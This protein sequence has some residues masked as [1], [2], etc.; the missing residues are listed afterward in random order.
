VIEAIPVRINEPNAVTVPVAVILADDRAIE[1]P[2]ADTVASPNI[3][4]DADINEKPSAVTVVLQ[5][6]SAFPNTSEPL[7][8][9]VIVALQFIDA[10]A[11]AI[12]NPEADTVA[13]DVIDAVKNCILLPI[14]VSVALEL[15]L[16]D[17]NC[18]LFAIA[19]N[20]AFA[21]TEATPSCICP[22]SARVLNGTCD[23][24]LI[25]NINYSVIG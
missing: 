3:E 17:E 2:V 16:P 22:V 18:I 8:T 13:S 19:L 21:V 5:L 11:S 20:V 15:I 1:P 24:A 6:T 12:E 25:P 14:A 9:T 23:N 4:P 7:V 10:L